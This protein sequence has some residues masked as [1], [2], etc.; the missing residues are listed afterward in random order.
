MPRQ[1][2]RQ[3]RRNRRA[4]LSV[5]IGGGLRI[6][7]W[8]R[9][10]A[11]KRAAA[12]QDR[13]REVFAGIRRGR[14]GIAHRRHHT[15]RT[16]CL[17]RRFACD[18]RILFFGGDPDQK[19]R[20]RIARSAIFDRTRIFAWAAKTDASP[21]GFVPQILSCSRRPAGGEVRGEFLLSASQSDAAT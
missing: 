18:R 2:H 6:G 19:S 14:N 20:R 10:A 8:F 15:R 17:D 7:S 12:L 3:D 11:Q 16:R 5:W 13:E 1:K 21:G 4:R 9:S